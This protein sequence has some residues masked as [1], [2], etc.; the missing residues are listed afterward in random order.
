VGLA[1]GALTALPV[2]AQTLEEVLARYVAARGGLDKIRAVKTIRMSGTMTAGPGVE[3]PF[4]Q[5]VKRPDL[6]R[7]EFTL[8]G[9]T[10]VQAFDGE[11]AW[12]ML[13]VP[14]APPPRVLSPEETRA[15]E[16]DSDFDGPLVDYRQKGN[17]VELVGKEH[18]PGGEAWKLKLT[19]KSGSERY[20][21]LD[22]QSFLEVRGEARR[23]VRG[24][25]LEGEVIFSDFRAVDGLVFP[26]AIETGPRGSSRK[27][28]LVIEK[29]E[30]N[31]PIDES[32]F[33]RPG[34]DEPESE[35]PE[36]PRP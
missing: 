11:T 31:V 3:A 2:S 23:T 30:L 7:L 14:Q 21:Y 20:L 35:E 26:Y 33:R 10:G 15:A 5:E 34:D 36:T 28:K 29:I 13:P 6:R 24:R 9:M 12:V 1:L 27:Q 19:L 17:Q 8:R 32:R 25:D 16:E 22:A 18:L 4:T